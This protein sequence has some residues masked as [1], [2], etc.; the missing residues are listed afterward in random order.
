MKNKFIKNKAEIAQLNTH[1]PNYKY[2]N[3]LLKSMR[4]KK[5]VSFLVKFVNPGDNIK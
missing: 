5:K 2:I 3:Y 1:E 4:K